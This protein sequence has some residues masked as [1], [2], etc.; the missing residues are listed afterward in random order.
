MSSR[1]RV[2]ISRTYPS[3]LVTALQVTAEV[4][5][6]RD[7]THGFGIDDVRQYAPGLTA[8][9]NQGEIPINAAVLETTPGLRIVANASIGVNNLELPAARERGIWCTNTPTA[10]AD[11]TA[12]CTIG[13]L[14]MLA[15][16]LGEGERFVRA[17]RWRQFTPGGW[18]GILL[19]GHT[20]GL[21]G[22]GN[23]GRAVARRAE[24]FGL[25]VLH[26][27]RRQS[28]L[29]GWRSLDE[30]LATCNFVSLHVPL[31]AETRHLIDA[32]RLARMKRGAFLLNLARGP[33]VDE[34]A[35]I[36][37]LHSGQL[38]GAALDV[39]E[40]EPNVPAELCAMENVVLTP[41]V[42]GGSR[43]GRRLA[44][45]LCVENVLRVLRGESPRTDCIVSAPATQ[46]AVR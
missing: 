8:I 14:L 22:Y 21:V 4:I 10:F 43:E 29:P 26:H 16:R 33:V 13:L 19:R 5:Q 44:Q 35:L 3:D 15:R 46:P 28:G 23:I 24:G 39:F 36:A 17:G 18:D 41:H 45:E 42:G 9:I 7:E 34:S 2:L 6:P 40:D 32:T 25:K 31:T 38:A 11:A 37:A 27:T 20:L 1:S 30:L 12:D